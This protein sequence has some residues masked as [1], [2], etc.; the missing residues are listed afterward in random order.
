MAASTSGGHPERETKR[1]PPAAEEAA[2]PH[3]SI[4]SAAKQAPPEHQPPAATGQHP[5]LQE[6]ALQGRGAQQAAQALPTGVCQ[7]G[8]L[9]RSLYTTVGHLKYSY[10]NYII[11]YYHDGKCYRHDDSK[12]IQR[13]GLCLFA[14]C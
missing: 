9:R 10:F 12:F 4:W 8:A 5:A 11:V 1:G 3:Q 2:P 6:E 14:R 13:V 7:L